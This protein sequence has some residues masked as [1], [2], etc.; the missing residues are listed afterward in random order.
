[1][2]DSSKIRPFLRKKGIKKCT[3]SVTSPSLLVQYCLCNAGD[4]LLQT[5]CNRQAARASS[6]VTLP[7]SVRRFSSYETTLSFNDLNKVQNLAGKYTDHG[8]CLIFSKTSVR[9]TFSEMRCRM[10]AETH[11]AEGSLVQRTV[12]PL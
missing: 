6:D 3:H 5:A 11:V 9:Q 4:A 12:A 8:K 1:M 10:R 2:P 7:K